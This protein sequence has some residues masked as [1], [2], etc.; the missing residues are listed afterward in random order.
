[1]VLIVL[2]VAVAVVVVVVVVLVVINLV[3]IDVVG[4]TG[5]PGYVIFSDQKVVKATL[6]VYNRIFI[7][8]YMKLEATDFLSVFLKIGFYSMKF[9][10]MKKYLY[11]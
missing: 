1:M 6:S 10:N 7:I 2:V 3:I 9:Q 5:L 11:M 4:V 8:K